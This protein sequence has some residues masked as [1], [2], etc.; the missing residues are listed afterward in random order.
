[1]S[2]K[3]M[4]AVWEH[5]KHK[6]GALLLMLS[7]ADRAN[8]E[9]YCWPGLPDLGKRCRV[10]RPTV[11][12]YTIRAELSKELLVNRRP[13]KVNKYLVV[14]G[15]D[16]KAIPT[17]VEKYFK[18]GAD[19]LQCY[20]LYLAEL[21]YAQSVG[22]KPVLPTTRKPV[23]PA[24]GKT[25]LPEPSITPIETPDSPNGDT[26]PAKKKKPKKLTAI[27]QA[28]KAIPDWGDKFVAVKEGWGMKGS[29]PSVLLDQLQGISEISA[30]LNIDPPAT[31]KEIRGFAQWYKSENP[32]GIM[33]AKPIVLEDHFYRYREA[34]NSPNGAGRMVV[35]NGVEMTVAEAIALNEATT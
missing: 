34:A 26:P 13:G 25:G 27:Q 2:L 22:R 21:E 19:E 18:W 1:M 7:L 5:S 24:P 6:G 23:L 28:R 17:L 11:N 10:S 15:I 16:Q 30:D 9:G 12:K 14:T 31:L 3:R 4:T 20:D 32:D 8:D 29:R 35:V 33:P